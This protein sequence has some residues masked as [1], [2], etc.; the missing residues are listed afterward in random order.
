MIYMGLC[1]KPHHPLKR[2][3]LNFI[4]I[5]LTNDFRDNIFNLKFYT[6]LNPNDIFKNR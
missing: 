3:D 5:I 6:N 1:P 2:V 4:K